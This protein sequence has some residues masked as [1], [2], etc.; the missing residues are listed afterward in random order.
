MAAFE[1]RS[2]AAL[3]DALEGLGARLREL[4]EAIDWINEKAEIRRWDALRLKL[5]E[6]ESLSVLIEARRAALEP[7]A[8]ATL[9]P[10]LDRLIYDV[11]FRALEAEARLVE[12]QHKKR[13]VPLF[14]RELFSQ[15]LHRLDRLSR[16][17]RETSPEPSRDQLVLERADHR[18]GWLQELIRRAPEIPDFGRL[19]RGPAR[20]AA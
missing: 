12:V 14:G 4:F 16:Q 13:E 10:W 19:L 8:A 2:L 1:S 6:F 11:A 7:A 3:T 17:V 15:A 9:K 20:A 5:T 18:R